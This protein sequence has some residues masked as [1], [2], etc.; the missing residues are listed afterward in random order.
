[1]KNRM[2]KSWEYKIVSIMGYVIIIFLE[3]MAYIYGIE[4][5]KK[6]GDYLIR[7]HDD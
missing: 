4:N 7:K 2:I 1:M 5:V 3:I 6:F